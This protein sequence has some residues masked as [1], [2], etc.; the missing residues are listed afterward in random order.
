MLELW[1]ILFGGFYTGAAETS[2]IWHDTWA[3]DYNSNTWTNR[4]IESK[5]TVR[6]MVPI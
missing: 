1:I 5:P 3:F 4:T 6:A 2:V